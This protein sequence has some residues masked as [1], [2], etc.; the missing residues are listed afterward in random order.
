MPSTKNKIGL[1]FDGLEEMI[2]NLEKVR[3]I[4]LCIRAH[5]LIETLRG[6]KF[7]L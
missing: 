1:K 6:C 7:P 3:I 5:I 2:S 4:L